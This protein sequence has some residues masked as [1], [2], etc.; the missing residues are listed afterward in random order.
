MS[1][2]RTPNDN[3]IGAVST[4]P[5]R[6]ITQASSTSTYSMDAMS[7]KLH[8]VLKDRHPTH[9]NRVKNFANLT[10]DDIIGDNIKH[11]LACHCHK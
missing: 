7:I 8:E 1:N 2:N 4:L 11:A 3:R 6:L 9:G 10:H 5:I